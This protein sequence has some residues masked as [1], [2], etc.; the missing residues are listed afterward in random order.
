M[1]TKYKTIKNGDLK[2]N[3]V[4]YKKSITGTTLSG[5][6]VYNLSKLFE[7]MLN[8]DIKEIDYYDFKE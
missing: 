3:K 1:V 6:A 8:N 7:Y 4:P 5:Y 2:V